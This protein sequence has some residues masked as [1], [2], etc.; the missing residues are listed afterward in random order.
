MHIGKLRELVLTK[1]L[2]ILV[3]STHSLASESTISQ[4]VATES[5]HPYKVDTNA[6][7][8]LVEYRDYLC[9]IC[10]RHRRGVTVEP[11][12]KYVKTG[13][14]KIE[15]LPDRV[16]TLVSLQ[17]GW[18]NT[19]LSQLIVLVTGPNKELETIGHVLSNQPFKR[20]HV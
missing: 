8:A 19:T 15:R 16:S 2:M 6:P 13:K 18:V 5:G 9:P 4:L 14:L 11:I 7:V 20:L 10:V 1:F 3:V 17:Q 12:D